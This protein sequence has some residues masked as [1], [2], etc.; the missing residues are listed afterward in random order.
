MR[1]IA[2]I[3]AVLAVAPSLAH[4]GQA[5]YTVTDVG[6]IPGTHVSVAFAINNAGQVV[7]WGQGPGSQVR[8]FLYTPGTGIVELP[9]PEG[10]SEGYATDISNNGI[11]V[12]MAKNG[13]AA[14]EARAWRMV[15]GVIELLPPFPS[16]CPGMVP[17][18]VNDLGDV[19]G[20]TCPDS[21]GPINPWF[22][23]DETGLVDLIPFG[24]GTAVDINDARVVTGQSSARPAYRWQA[25]AG[26]LELLRPLPA[27]HEDGATGL[28]LNESGEIAGYGIRA[29]SGPDHWRAFSAGRGRQRTTLVDYPGPARSGGYGINEKGVVVGNSG[30]EST[31]EGTGWVW[32]AQTGRRNLVDLIDVPGIYGIRN[33]KDINDRGQI[34]AR[35]TTDAPYGAIVVLTPTR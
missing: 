31:P 10:F 29:L 12:G 5:A 15:G 25:P 3:A 27:P 8:P 1:S 32:T 6:T 14:N 28:A 24:I 17:D 23:S 26:P 4:A 13:L 21:G 19:V 11:V 35:A 22:F 30:T 20:S 7:G 33:A 34:V 16:S 2:I 18:A 9:L